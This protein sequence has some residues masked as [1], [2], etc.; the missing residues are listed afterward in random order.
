M[1]YIAAMAKIARNKSTG[2]F[3]VAAN[4]KDKPATI[5]DSKS[6]RTLP[7][8]GYGAL[9]GEFEIRK[10]L[11]LSQPIAAQV[12]KKGTGGKRPATGRA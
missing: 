2:R 7:L 4:G 3:T 5:R 9:K 8:K 6:G 10:D 1:A 12:A 11:D